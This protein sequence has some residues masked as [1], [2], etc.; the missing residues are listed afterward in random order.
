M[1]D[2]G[3]SKVCT[4]WKDSS[5]PFSFYHLYISCLSP[6]VFTEEED[7]AVKCKT[8][9]HFAFLIRTLVVVDIVWP[10]FLVFWPFGYISIEFQ[11]HSLKSNYHMLFK[12]CL[13]VHLQFNGHM[14]S[15]HCNLADIKEVIDLSVKLYQIHSNFFTKIAYTPWRQTNY[16]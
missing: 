12:C 2:H 13:M 1:Q 9:I 8:D 15:W 7:I 4:Q 5:K 11:V 10:I 3:L 14:P 16:L 6:A